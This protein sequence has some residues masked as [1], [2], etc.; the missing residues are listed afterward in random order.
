MNSRYEQGKK[1]SCQNLFGKGITVWFTGLPASGKTTIASRIAEIL[2]SRGYS[3]CHLDGD[4]LR[5]GLNSDLGF[6]TEDRMENIRRASE[7]A[8]LLNDNHVIVLAA[9]ITP[10]ESTRKLARNILGK[11]NLV[12]VYVKCSIK[13]C[14]KR[15]P[16]GLY[17]KAV[18]GEIDN[19]TGISAEYEEPEKPD[20]IVDT[21]KLDIDGCV[22]RVMGILE[23][24]L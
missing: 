9:F 24:Y 23:D 18:K 8:K 20:I 4:K 19:F 10:I 7:T 22:N 2:A 5:K 17:K 3:A 14:K 1:N 16:K 6:S 12:E 15:D 11:D 13:E 21:E